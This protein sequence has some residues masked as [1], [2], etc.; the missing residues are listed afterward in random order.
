MTTRS[1]TSVTLRAAGALAACLTIIAA[2]AHTAAAD[3][4]QQGRELFLADDYPAAEPLLRRCLE[5][6]DDLMALLP[7]TVI[8]VTQQRTAEGLEFGSRALVIAPDN[9]NVRYWY[10]RALLQA[11]RLP[12]AREQWER[13]MGLDAGHAGILEGLARISIQEGKPAQ[14]YNLLRQMNMQGV[15]E[16]WLQRLL[17][18]LA[19]GQGHWDQAAVHLREV[20]EREGPS[21]KD[22]LLLGELLILAGRPQEAVAMLREAVAARPTGALLG[23]LGEALF[24]SDRMDSAAVVLQQAVDADPDQPRHR[25]NLANALELLQRHEEAGGHFRGYLEDRPDDPVGRFHYAVH[26]I[27]REQLQEARTELE[28]AVQLDQQYV[29]ARIVLAQLYQDLGRPE[30][31]LAE[32]DEL[33]RLD[34]G[35][36][37][38]LE[39]WRTQLLEDLDELR[40]APEGKVK[41]Q[42]IVVAEEDLARRVSRELSEGV[43]FAELAARHSLGP[44]AVRGGEIGWVDP[45]EMVPALRAAI[46]KLQPGATSPPVEAGGQYHVLR[47]IR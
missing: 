40:D 35:S 32:V 30:A 26:L 1:L 44:T 12:E 15:S 8:T 23:G 9:A 31:A 18:D 38:E 22:Q 17:A 2:P 43:P 33:V 28:R 41:L 47:R 45:A 5:S 13:G 20:I 29:Q 39:Q 21:E 42:H 27:N 46:E 25:F 11:G 3:P 10:G 34:P 16:P 4:C 7:L 37:D 19:R 36:R 14:A 6:G 24:T